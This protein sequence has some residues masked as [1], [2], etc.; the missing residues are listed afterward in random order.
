MIKK[1]LFLSV[2]IMCTTFTLNAQN[3]LL[4]G[5]FEAGAGNVFTNWTALNGGSSL[6]S[7]TTQIH[8][9]LRA[10]KAIPTG[11]AG[12]QWK[13]QLESDAVT[14]VIGKSYELS[15]WVKGANAGNTV[16]FSNNIVT[17]GS[18][19][20][21]TTAWQKIFYTFTATATTTKIRLELGGSTA[22]VNTFYVDD[23][24]MYDVSA[25][26][27]NLIA[28][29]DLEVGSGDVTTNWSR[30]NNP[31]NNITAETLEIH[32]GNRALKIV[33]TGSNQWD[34]QLTSDAMTLEV[35]RSYTASMWIKTTTT[36]K[37][38]RFSTAT[39][40]AGSENYGG[41]TTIVGDNNWQQITYTFIAKSASTKLNLD[42][43][44]SANTTFYIDDIAFMGV[45]PV[46]AIKNIN[47][48]NN[49]NV[50]Y[51]NPV[52][53]NLNIN[54]DTDI[55]SVIISDLSGKTV[56]TINN[57]VNIQSVNLSDLNQGIYILSTD[58]NKQFKFIKK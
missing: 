16:R 52:T 36:G 49:K 14:T 31:N 9:G 40:P 34:V 58:T 6:T 57:A 4:N 55:K 51:P 33:S 44:G 11:V 45:S 53:D 24:A 43:G 13:L 46:L 2:A 35:G 26:S 54:S 32:G 12:E 21:V 17:Y 8:G 15:M 10:L 19:V 56:R 23:A 18:D 25:T 30:S 20:A 41:N 47:I 48:E 5:N 42:L 28:N 37:T 50:F 1:L 39:T 38:V 7:E 22:A 27:K 29:G 3:L